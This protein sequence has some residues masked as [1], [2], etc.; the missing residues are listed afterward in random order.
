MNNDSI[1]R[2]SLPCS[3]VHTSAHGL[4]LAMREPCMQ[5]ALAMLATS[6]SWYDGVGRKVAFM[7]RNRF[8]FCRLS[9]VRVSFILTNT[10]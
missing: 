8:V 7:S 4:A 3:N 5:D 10:Y 6:G 2:S 1:R 9:I